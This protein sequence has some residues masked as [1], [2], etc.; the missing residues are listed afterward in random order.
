MKLQ[1][2]PTLIPYS[3]SDHIHI[4]WTVHLLKINIHVNQYMEHIPVIIMY[5]LKHLHCLIFKK[6][7]MTFYLN[8]NIHNIA[9][10]HKIKK[11]G[12]KMHFLD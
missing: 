2:S 10:V 7:S 11:K 6:C 9:L 3:P 12:N 1:L 8:Y 5:L 4:S